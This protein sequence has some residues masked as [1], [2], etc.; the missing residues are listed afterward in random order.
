M[1]V[2]PG[3]T[4]TPRAFDLR[5]GIAVR[6]LSPAAELFQLRA[7][8]VQP[9]C[10][11]TRRGLVRR[12]VSARLE[13]FLHWEMEMFRFVLLVLQVHFVVSGVLAPMVTVSVLRAA[14]LH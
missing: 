4:A 10:T 3:S 9:E 11:A 5:L 8:R 12:R 2:L 6:A 13:V 1:R 7:R 14:F